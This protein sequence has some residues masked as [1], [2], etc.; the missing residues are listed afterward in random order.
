MSLDVK[1]AVGLTK[2]LKTT[3]VGGEHTPHHQIDGTVAVTDNGGSLTVDGTV[4]LGATSLSALENIQVTFPSTQNVSVQNTS[5]AVTDN[6]GSLTVDGPLTNSELRA[7]VVPVSV[8]GVSTAANQVTANSSLSSIDGKLPALS[9]GRVPVDIGGSGSITI[10]SGTV[11][12]SNEVEVKN[13]SS[14]PLPVSGAVSSS[15]ADGSGNA[16]TSSARGSQRAL[17][18]QVVDGSGNQITTF[19]SGTVDSNTRDGSGNAITSTTQGSTRRLDVMLSSSGA[20]G[21]TA[22]T[23]AN[24]MGGTDGTNLRGLSVDSSGRPNVNVNGTVPVSGTV[25]TNNQALTTGTGSISGTSAVG[26][27]LITSTDVS[28]FAEASIQ[29]NGSWPSNAYVTPQLSNDNS[30]WISTNVLNISNTS[31][32][33]ANSFTAT[34]VNNLCRVGLFG[35]R[36]FRLRVTQAGTNSTYDFAYTLNPRSTNANVQSVNVANAVLYVVPQTSQSGHANYHTL[37]SAA[38]T[39]AQLVNGVARAIGTITLANTTSSYK[40]FKLINKNAIPVAGADTPVLNYPIPPMTTLDLNTSSVAIRMTNGIAYVITGGQ[41]LMDA[42]A[43]GAGDVV[44]NITW[45]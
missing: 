15:I 6:G 29:F 11:T 1:D 7:S 42:T 16:L 17:S 12:V 43:I 8:S 33:V 19:G 13:D 41:A 39:N 36:Y 22:P 32:I 5:L 20:T 35:A 31:P 26:T 21:S 23:N 2:A 28:G 30:T 40:Y 18:V 3:L 10:T 38:G 4:E 14:N 37:I 34:Q 9:S 45:S 25:T 27:D 44:V 24:L